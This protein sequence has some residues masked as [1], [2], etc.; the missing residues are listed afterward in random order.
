MDNKRRQLLKA[1]LLGTGAI[2]L[3]NPLQLST[4][5]NVP[6][7]SMQSIQHASFNGKSLRILILG[8]SGFLGPH[9]V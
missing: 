8:G 4:A 5:K 3:G 2:V 6:V 1:G 7:V 9:M